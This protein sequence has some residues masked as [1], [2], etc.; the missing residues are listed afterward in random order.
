MPDGV[1]LGIV[2]FVAVA[3]WDFFHGREFQ[4]VKLIGVYSGAVACRN[5]I[6]CLPMAW[7]EG[8][9]LPP[10]GRDVV[11]IGCLTVITALAFQMRGARR[12]RRRLK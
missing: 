5:A 8:M 3:S 2:G 6:D 10:G 4:V 11:A 12:A 1:L 9:P 7:T